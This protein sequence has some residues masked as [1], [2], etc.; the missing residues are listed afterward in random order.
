MSAWASPNHEGVMSKH[1]RGLA[2]VLLTLAALGGAAG[3]DKGDSPPPKIPKEVQ[4]I[5]GTYVGEWTMYGVNAKG[6][7]VPR[8]TWTDT[9]K[10]ETPKVEGNRAFVTI[11]DEM[12]FAGAKTPVKATGK[13]GYFLNKDGSLG[14]YFIEMRGDVRRMVKLSDTAWSYATKAA[15]QELEQLG[16]PKGSTGEHVLVKFVSGSGADEVHRIVRMTNVHWKDRD[17]K[18][19]WTQ[20]VSLK[21][22]H[23]RKP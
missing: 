8:M 2:A 4:A 5:A 21:G 11:V 13:E 14:D 20:F 23:K 22:H 19:Q 12:T 10:A 9:L 1:L 16:F 17:G 18:E 7:A 6:E 3:A 15:P